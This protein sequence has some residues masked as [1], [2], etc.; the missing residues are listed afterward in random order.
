MFKQRFISLLWWLLAITVASLL[1]AA[2][3][4]KKQLPCSEVKVE[5]ED[6]EGHVFV[7]EKD[8]ITILKNN[9]VYEGKSISNIDLHKLENIIKQGA[10]IKNAEL[11]FNNK[12][13]LQVKIKEREPIA[14]I[15]TLQGTSFYID[16]TGKRLPLSNDYSARVPMFTSFTS[17]KKKLSNPD[18][19]LLDDVRKIALYIQQDSFW[20]A[21]VSQVVITPQ[22]TFEIIPVAGNQVIQFGKADS[23]SSKFDR[24]FSFYKQVWAKA[25]FEKYETINVQFS[26]QV[27]AVK[28]GAP[29][30]II[31]SASVVKITDAMR[32]GVDILKDSSLLFHDVAIMQKNKPD[33]AQIQTTKHIFDLV[34]NNTKANN[35]HNIIKPKTSATNTDKK[36]ISHPKAMMPKTKKKL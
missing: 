25:G 35:V 34:I 15:F 28:R 11:F 1:A 7:D 18:S 9:G 13:V 10:W 24:L 2:V 16:S 8:V 14:R 29:K 19:L 26:G 5:I 20:N 22:S 21:Q 12:Q 17:D 31:D 32:K 3:Q 6:N 23:L 33:T 4:R 30:P 36:L 27:V